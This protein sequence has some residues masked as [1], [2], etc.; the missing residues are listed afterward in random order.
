MEFF[1]VK[2]IKEFSEE[3]MKKVKLFDTEN[4]FCDLYC[5]KPDQFQKIHTHQGADKVYFVLEGVGNFYIGDGQRRL[6]NGTALLA[7]AGVMH[8]VVN[9]STSEL[10]ILVFMAPNPNRND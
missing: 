6:K 8:G 4:F 5:L 3:K 2:K 10:I 9:D 7:P 1:D